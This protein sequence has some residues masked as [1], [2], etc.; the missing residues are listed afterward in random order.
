MSL[1]FASLE[2]QSKALES[3]SKP[4]S[5]E[6]AMDEDDPPESPAG[7]HPKKRTNAAHTEAKEKPPPDQTNGHGEGSKAPKEHHT[8]RDTELH[9][10][11]KTVSERRAAQ[12]RL[13]LENKSLDEVRSMVAK[14]KTDINNRVTIFGDVLD[15][16]KKERKSKSGSDPTEAEVTE[17]NRQIES[18]GDAIMDAVGNAIIKALEDDKSNSQGAHTPQD[19]RQAVN[20]ILKLKKR[21]ATHYQLL[22]VK[23]DENTEQIRKAYKKLAPKL[24][25]DK[26]EDKD[27]EECIAAINEAVEILSDPLKRKKYDAFCK[28]NQPPKEI[29]TF[30]EEFAPSAFDA[31]SDSDDATEDDESDD[32]EDGEADYP[33][34]SKVVR[35]LHADIGK[36]IVKGFFKSL[37]GPVKAVE[38]TEA[39]NNYNKSIMENNQTCK[40]PDPRMFTVPPY[41]L[42]ACQY[43]QRSIAM[44]YELRA[45]NERARREIQELQKYFETTRRRR[46]YQW[47]EAWTEYL[48]KPL[49]KRL[50]ERGLPK[51]YAKTMPTQPKPIQPKPQP[52][53]T[54]PKSAQAESTQGGSRNGD[55]EDTTMRDANTDDFK[56]LEIL[57]HS[58]PPRSGA[59]VTGPGGFKYFHDVE[60]PNKLSI[61]MADDVDHAKAAAYHGSN[62]ENNIQE[63]LPTYRFMGR[64][65]YEGI[66][67]VAFLPETGNNERTCYTYVRVGI[68]GVSDH[69]PIMTRSAL[70]GWLGH[71]KADQ[72]IDKFFVKSG[73][74]PPWAMDDG[75]PM[76]PESYYQLTYPLPSR[77]HRRDEVVLRGRDGTDFP[78]SRNRGNRYQDDGIRELT[79]KVDGFTNMFTMFIEEVRKQRQQTEEIFRRLLPAPS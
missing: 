71:K 37:D 29:N 77:S 70:R 56:E 10:A 24:H 78:A 21:Q 11:V 7:D 32:E 28:D 51:E 61:R 49:L 33:D 31:D 76:K 60:G 74:V 45:E 62:K 22:G 39:L 50:E 40:M 18:N 69:H 34:P 66:I 38:L 3:V 44:S 19:K 57:A 35:G 27:A 67:G 6:E 59:K 8:G 43:T 23:E 53:P 1:S 9:A 41:K 14:S 4:R 75:D 20:R 48:M 73:T 15:A 63:K 17:I 16:V 30:G 79:E 54:Q 12:A 2:G 25:P 65:R 36:R 68:R 46:L 47:P 64:E 55:T 42:L 26:N 5:E 72:E 13:T 52:K 58:C